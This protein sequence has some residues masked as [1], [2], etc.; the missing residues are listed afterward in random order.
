MKKSTLSLIALFALVMLFLSSCD[1]LSAVEYTADDTTDGAQIPGNS[2]AESIDAPKLPE[3]HFYLTGTVSPE[4]I[5]ELFGQGYSPELSRW[6]PVMK[7]DSTNALNQ[8]CTEAGKLMPLDYNAPSSFAAA[9]TE[10]DDAYF[11]ENIL[12]IGSFWSSVQKYGYA[13]TMYSKV[14]D[15]ITFGVDDYSSGADDTISGNLM[16]VELPR[17]EVEGIETFDAYLRD[18]DPTLSKADRECVIELNYGKRNYIFTGSLAAKITDDLAAL[19]FGGTVAD[20]WN[21]ELSL[22]I[23]T[24][25][26][27]YGY[28]DF[29]FNDIICDDG[30]AKYA[31]TGYL[32]QIIDHYPETVA[33]THC[34]YVNWGDDAGAAAI[35]ALA[36][37]SVT[38]MK[39]VVR[40]D[41]M[42]ELNAFISATDSYFDLDRTYDEVG[43]FLSVASS[44]DDD[45]FAHNCLLITYI[46]T[47]SGSYRYT[48]TDVNVDSDR[49]VMDIRR[50]T[51]W[52][53]TDDMAG[54]FIVVEVP[55]ALLTDVTHYGAAVK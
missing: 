6:F 14:E 15:R 23:S 49:L 13:L 19:S 12:A 44:Y 5:A 27:T 8:F 2:T 4:E 20:D 28:T 46:G 35:D 43:D 34:T 47:S 16:V 29:Y 3:T 40:V 7:I 11:A 54:W 50:S 10:Y 55:T 25:H 24:V 33:A 30:R 18:H 41:S 36:E 1:G 32:A 42:E 51:E 17:S 53:I 22:E 21:A 9:V 31:F 48:L 45:F 52:L 26:G 38:T 39:S 37:P